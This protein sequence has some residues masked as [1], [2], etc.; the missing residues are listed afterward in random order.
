VKGGGKAAAARR[1][2]LLSQNCRVRVRNGVLRCPH[3]VDQRKN[4]GAV[5]TWPGWRRPSFAGSL[6][7]ALLAIAGEAV[8]ALRG[9]S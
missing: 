9:R 8:A 6:P 4:L 7:V 1:K 5:F 2:P 3:T